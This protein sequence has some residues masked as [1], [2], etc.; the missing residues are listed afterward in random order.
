MRETFDAVI[1]DLNTGTAAVEADLFT[2]AAK[3]GNTSDTEGITRIVQ[4]YYLENPWV[5]T[6]A[7]VPVNA[8]NATAFAPLSPNSILQ[9]VI[10]SADSQNLTAGSIL[11]SGP[12]Y[13]PTRGYMMVVLVPVCLEDGTKAGTLV[14]SYDPHNFFT[15]LLLDTDRMDQYGLWVGTENY[16]TI[17]SST[18]DYV[19]ENLK[20]ILSSPTAPS[21][22]IT[23]YQCGEVSIFGLPERVCLISDIFN[24]TPVIWEATVTDPVL[25]AEAQHLYVY[26]TTHSREETLSYISHAGFVNDTVLFAY[27]T[28]GTVLAR[29][30]NRYEKQ[31]L[32]NY[33]DAY[34]VRTINKMIIRSMQGGG[35]TYDM[36][37]ITSAQDGGFAI[38][39]HSYLLPVTSDWFVGAQ[40]TLDTVPLT[41]TP[42]V[43][44]DVVVMTQNVLGYTWKYGKDATCAEI[45]RNNSTFLNNS[46]VSGKKI[47]AAV[48]MNGNILAL[49]G[50][51]GIDS[52]DLL[53]LVDC[54][55]ASV[56]RG[57]VS[58]VRD[59]GG[60][61]YYANGTLDNL[62]VS[63][64]YVMTVDDSWFVFSGT[65]IGT[66]SFFS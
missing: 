4:N 60:P 34:G 22:S 16:T 7:Y 51:L 55:G 1:S 37:P 29:S 47:F 11:H 57:I 15:E 5:R 24:K 53:S 48:D 3:I 56:G 39:A 64:L 14:V 30:D 32:L 19:D 6:V 25:A 21:D 42:R 63:L 10:Q 9:N 33:H 50:D 65:E 8:E 23:S 36:I 31:N 40:A 17:Y 46:T 66:F 12:H 45:S 61:V 52:K 43:I 41:V 2:V 59:G 13:T 28:N 18:P 26:A 54:Q 38:P 58:L 44:R 20:W 49:N 62:Q 35:H 27:D